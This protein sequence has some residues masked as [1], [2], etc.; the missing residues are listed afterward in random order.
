FNLLNRLAQHARALHQTEPLL[1]RQGELDLLADSAAANHGRDRQ[2]HIAN[3]VEPLLQR[4]DRQHAAAVQRQGVD[5]L[6]DRQTDAE[7]R[8][9][10]ELDELGAGGPG[11][12]EHFFL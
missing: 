10:L 3:A 2:A 4:T 1:L 6:A 5:D 12:F 9:A 11:F 8:A 7:A